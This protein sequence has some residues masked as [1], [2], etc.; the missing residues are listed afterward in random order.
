MYTPLSD[1][2]KTI[3]SLAQS[4]GFTAIAVAILALGGRAASPDQARPGVLEPENANEARLNQLQSPDR[5]MDAIGIRPGMAVAEIGAGQGRWVVQLAVRVGERGKVFA[6]DIDKAA[7]EHLTARCARWGLKNVEAIVG[8]TNDPKLPEGRLDRIFVISSYHHFEDPVA[9]LG[10]ARAALKPEGK[11][12]I[13]EWFPSQS[14]GTGGTPPERVKAQMAAAGYI[15]ERMETFLEA[16]G[17]Y[18][19]LFRLGPTR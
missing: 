14:A 13:G 5:T 12:A 6:E 8:D 16:N 11:L 9:L 19:Y 4:W 7:L 18:I 15:F 3:R 2:G 10:K 1:H 17:M